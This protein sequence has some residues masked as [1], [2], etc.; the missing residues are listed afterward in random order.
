MVKRRR[1]RKAGEHYE[2][3]I[4]GYLASLADTEV[5]A[6]LVVAG[7]GLEPPTPGL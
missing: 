6:L 7:E 1:P 3:N 4:R 2:V 5:S